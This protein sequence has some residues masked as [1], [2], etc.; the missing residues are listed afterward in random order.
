LTHATTR[1]RQP[2]EKTSG[3]EIHSGTT[4]NQDGLRQRSDMLLCPETHQIQP[5][6]K[7][8]HQREASIQCQWTQISVHENS[9]ENMVVKAQ[10]K[11]FDIDLDGLTW[12]KDDSALFR[13][14][15]HKRNIYITEDCPIE[16]DN[17]YIKTQR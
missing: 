7:R 16:R 1:N 4:I 5:C 8:G 14:A 3:Q 9:E 13:E 6:Q 15:T 2:S 11:N 12:F 17:R 10:T